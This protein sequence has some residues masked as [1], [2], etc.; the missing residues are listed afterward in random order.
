MKRYMLDTNIVSHLLR[1]HP[2]VVQH[3]TSLPMASLCIS[4]ITEAELR[5]GLAKRLGN[6]DLHRAVNELLIRVESVAWGSAAA[7]AYGRLRV[8]MMTSGKTLAPLDLLIASHALSIEAV[9][10][11]NDQALRQLLGLQVQDWTQA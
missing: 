3:V 9:L 4:S 11:T 7:Q 10:V 2:A 6:Q 8:E 1:Q 5:F